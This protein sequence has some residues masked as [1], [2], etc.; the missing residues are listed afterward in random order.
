[1]VRSKVKGRRSLYLRERKDKDIINYVESM[2]DRHDFSD[3]VRDLMRDGIRFREGEQ[4]NVLQ[5]NTF[6]HTPFTESFDDIKLEKKEVSE[7]DIKA[8]MDGFLATF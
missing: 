4:M 2:I 1:M 8:R 3:I 5:S 7:D 6:T